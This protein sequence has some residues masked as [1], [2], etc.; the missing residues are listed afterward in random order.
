MNKLIS[1]GAN[2]DFSDRD[3]LTA[4]HHAALSGFEDTVDALL[5]A[6]SDVNAYSEVYGTSLALASVKA[7]KNVA[8]KLL[9]SSSAISTP[10]GSLGSIMHAACAGGDIGIIRSLRKREIPLDITIVVSLDVILALVPLRRFEAIVDIREI[11][12]IFEKSVLKNQ[13]A[14]GSR[15]A[16][17]PFHLAALYSRLKALQYLLKH[18]AYPKIQSGTTLFIMTILALAKDADCMTLLI[19]SHGLEIDRKNGDGQTILT[20]AAKAGLD[21]CVRILLS[22]GASTHTQDS[23]GRTALFHA[24]MNGHKDCVDALTTAPGGAGVLN[25]PAYCSKH[26]AGHRTPIMIAAEYG[27]SACVQL[28]LAKGAKINP[29]ISC[30]RGENALHRAAVGGH[31]DIIR[32]LVRAGAHID[33]KDDFGCSPLIWAVDFGRKDAVLQLI[34]LGADVSLMDNEGR[35]A[36]E[37]A[38][39]RKSGK[40]DFVDILGHACA[41]GTALMVESQH[42]GRTDADVDWVCIERSVSWSSS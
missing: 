26:P 12:D 34:D 17:A 1:D 24:A 42:S 36:A 23:G 37:Y 9:A 32:M 31:P 19:K 4:L 2:V 20:I 7:R 22:R 35:T 21:V 40:I 15:I 29:T 8:E 5:T 16:L 41:D 6:G 39:A 33:G 10:A 25:S 18:G 14:Q 3:R 11:I 27:H 28:L 38:W 30:G 13:I